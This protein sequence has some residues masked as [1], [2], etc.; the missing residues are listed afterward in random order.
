[1]SS[2]VVNGEDAMKT[3]VRRRIHQ[4]KVLVPSLVSFAASREIYA[5][6]ELPASH[7]VTIIVRAWIGPT[8]SDPTRW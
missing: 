2:F 7:G 1:M 5:G 6:R 3:D 8:L 4:T